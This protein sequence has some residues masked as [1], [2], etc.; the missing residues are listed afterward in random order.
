MNNSLD[1]S[2]K[3]PASGGDL[4]RTARRGLKKVPS[5]RFKKINVIFYQA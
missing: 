5:L 4:E 2:G 3:L 1:G